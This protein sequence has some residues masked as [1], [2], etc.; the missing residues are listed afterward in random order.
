MIAHHD[1]VGCA[2]SYCS[3]EDNH[4]VELLKGWKS[5]EL[6]AACERVEVHKASR[7]PP[8][9]ASVQALRKAFKLLQDK[10]SITPD[11]EELWSRKN[12][13]EKFE[14]LKKLP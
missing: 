6:L 14:F 12:R 4:V 10:I 8:C 7:P 5:E 2:G 11:Y 3:K 1:P 9:P 13:E